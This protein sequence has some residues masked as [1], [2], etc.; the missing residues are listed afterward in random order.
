[1][2]TLNASGY[3][4]ILNPE[5]AS[6]SREW[7]MKHIADPEVLAVCLMHPQA[8]DK[9]DVEFVNTASD[10]LRCVSTMSVGFGS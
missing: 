7:V 5:D 4:V 9:V 6:P 3:E 10:K 1:M 8:S 2:S